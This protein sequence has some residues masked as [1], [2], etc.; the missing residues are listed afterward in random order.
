MVWP[1]AMKYFAEQWN[2]IKVGDDG[3]TPMEK[4]AGTTTD[5]TLRNHHTWG[6]PVY[7]LGAILQVNISVLSNW[8]PLPRAGMYLGHSPS[9]AGSVSLVLNPENGHVSPQLHLVFDDKFSTVPCMRKGKIP[10]N[11]K[12][13]VQHRS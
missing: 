1:Y 9:H 2:V 7:V 12:D 6:F 8:K 5:I 4:F 11:C 10:P 13:L 3:I